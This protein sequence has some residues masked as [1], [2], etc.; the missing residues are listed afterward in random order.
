MPMRRSIVWIDPGGNER[1]TQLTSAAGATVT[2]GLLQNLITANPEN[3]QE[4]PIVTPAFGSPAVT[5]YNSVGEMLA[6]SAIDGIGTSYRFFIPAPIQGLFTTDDNTVDTTNPLFFTLNAQAAFTL[7]VPQTSLDVIN[8]LAGWLFRRAQT[9]R[10][11]YICDGSHMTM[12]MCVVWQDGFGKTTLTTYNG[13]TSM[14]NF[15]AAADGCS[16]AIPVQY[17]EGTMN[18]IPP[19]PFGRG[20]YVSCLD[21]ARL[22]F[23]DANGNRTQVIAPAPIRAMFL[24][25]G[26]T[27]DPSYGPVVS[28]VAAA[29]TELIVPSSGLPVVEFIGGNLVRS[30]Q[31]GTV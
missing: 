30:N 24:A 3:W 31:Q 17:W 23:A 21:A 15:L 13:V 4:G 12:R 7:I 1:M 14:A 9:I 5:P 20:M 29:L 6:V 26:K 10:E 11:A 22:V 8:L 16:N 18:N 19:L 25:D 27:V 2:Y 28:L